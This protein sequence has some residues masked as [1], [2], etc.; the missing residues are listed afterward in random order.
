MQ[1]KGVDVA[2]TTVKREKQFSS[3]IPIGIEMR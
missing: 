3:G 2:L 1:I